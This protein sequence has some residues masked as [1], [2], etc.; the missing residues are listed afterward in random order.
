MILYEVRTRILYKL[1]NVL[2]FLQPPGVYKNIWYVQG[3]GQRTLVLIPK[4][5]C[6][7]ECKAMQ[8]TLMPRQICKYLIICTCLHYRVLLHYF[9]NQSK[10][11][12]QFLRRYCMMYQNTNLGSEQC[13]F[14]SGQKQKQL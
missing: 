9:I 14:F 5:E 8:F 6:L 4:G 2:C 1:Y 10:Q 11:D 3:H 13:K 12:T 7:L